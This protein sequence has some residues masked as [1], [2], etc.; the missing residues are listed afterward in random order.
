MCSL[1]LAKNALHSPTSH[2]PTVWQ[3]QGLSV[4]FVEDTVASLPPLLPRAVNNKKDCMLKDF[5]CTVTKKLL[6]PKYHAHDL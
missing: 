3:K 5:R 6:L 2:L 1:P 4:T